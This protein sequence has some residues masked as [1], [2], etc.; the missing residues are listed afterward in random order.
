MPVLT[1]AD[2][3]GRKTSIV[4]ALFKRSNCQQSKRQR[5]MLPNIYPQHQQIHLRKGAT[6]VGMLPNIYS[7]HKQIQ[8][9]KGMV[10]GLKRFFA[11]L[12]PQN[13]NISALAL[14]GTPLRSRLLLVQALND[15]IRPKAA[16]TLAEVLI[17]LGIIG[18]VAAMTIPNLISK[19]REKATVAQV[20]ETYSILSQGFRRAID[21]YGDVSSWCV[22]SDNT[23]E[24]CAEQIAENL[25]HFVRLS[26]CKIVYPGSK[27]V[28]KFYKTRF[29]GNN[30]QFG[31]LWRTTYILNNGSVIQFS[32]GNGDGY[33]SSWCTAGLNSGSYQGVCGYISLDI[34]G[35]S[36][37]NIDGKDLF[38]FKIY[39]DGISPLGRKKDDVWI[40]TFNNGCMGRHFYQFGTCTGWIIEQGNME[41]L[42]NS[43]LTY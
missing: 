31:L 3:D 40:E 33:V 9:R 17:T 30:S 14:N 34:N 7:Q 28:A 4:K 5:T 41:Y 18:V 16:F 25:S 13:D 32:A 21:E 35:A 36:G 38:R 19:A 43:D 6:H 26:P 12:L 8:L 37:P 15:H 22:R 2:F 20:K 42:H 1:G 10:D 29:K 27:C 39:Q 11:R 23:E 24:Q